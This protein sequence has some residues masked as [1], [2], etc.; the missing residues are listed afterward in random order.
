MSNLKLIPIS[1]TSK[2]F[3]KTTVSYSSAAIWKIFDDLN[4]GKVLTQPEIDTLFDFFLSIGILV[5]KDKYP[6]KVVIYTEKDGFLKH[7]NQV[8]EI[9]IIIEKMYN[10]FVD[11]PERVVGPKYFPT[12]PVTTS[13]RRRFHS[14]FKSKA[15]N[16]WTDNYRKEKKEA[17]GRVITNANERY[18]EGYDANKKREKIYTEAMTSKTEILN[19][20]SYDINLLEICESGEIFDLIKVKATKILQN[21]NLKVALRNN[22]PKLSYGDLSFIIKLIFQNMGFKISLIDYTNNYFIIEGPKGSI[23]RGLLD[24]EI[25]ETR[26]VSII[27][28]SPTEED[29]YNLDDFRKL[30]GANSIFLISTETE[31][32]NFRSFRRKNR[33][34]SNYAIGDLLDLV[35]LIVRE[36]DNLPQIEKDRL[37]ELIQNL[38]SDF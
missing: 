11:K 2:I 23:Y 6:D 32:D 36:F 15:G 31:S 25:T 7:D 33:K 17:L 5:I 21:M 18:G 29:L 14:H 27:C 24:S 12:C 34:I 9:M 8:D 28:N 4:S 38:A 3:S 22:L 16:I 35:D 10:Y 19:F 30:R 26:A 37:E 20:E 13:E 1:V